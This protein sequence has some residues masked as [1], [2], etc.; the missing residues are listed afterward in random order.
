MDDLVPPLLLATREIRFNLLAGRAL[1]DSVGV[2]LRS[3]HDEFALRLNELW[4]LKLQ[5]ESEIAESTLP[6][7]RSRALWELLERGLLGEPILEPLQHLEN[8]IEAAATADLE[9]HI[10][11]L[12]FKAL[13]PLLFF[14]FPAFVILLIG[15]LLRDLEKTLLTIIGLVL[16]AGPQSHAESLESLAVKKL[17]HARTSREVEA[18]ERSVEELRVARMAC[19]IQIRAQSIPSVCYRALKIEAAWGLH[20]D[21]KQ[22]RALVARMDRLCARNAKSLKEIPQSTSAELTAEC[23]KNVEKARELLAYKWREY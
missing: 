9:T 1:K 18:I 14:Q 19:E 22:T 15:P 2:Y 3:H 7:H 13:I 12:P 6:G 5:G 16:L 21:S 10:A 23:R 17:S 20:P 4:C 8:D 11:T